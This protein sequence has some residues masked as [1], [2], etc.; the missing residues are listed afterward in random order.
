MM[1]MRNLGRLSALSSPERRLLAEAL[2]MLTVARALVALLPFRTIGR[3]A[4]RSS[5]AKAPMDQRSATLAVAWAVRA[6]ARRVPFRAKCFEQGLAAA[7]MLRHRGV[8]STLHFGA[9]REREQLLA[10]VWITAN[11]EDVIGCENKHLFFELTRFSMET[12][13]A[14]S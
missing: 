13:T 10:H 7:L 14:C 2:Y 4:A 12:R 1:M 8:D 9:A 5:S 6:S 11:G 3:L